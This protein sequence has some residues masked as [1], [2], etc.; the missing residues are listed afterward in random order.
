MLRAAAAAGLACLAVQ[1]L[2]QGKAVK[3]DYWPGMENAVPHVSG[4][5]KLTNTYDD[6]KD[7]ASIQRAK[8]AGK[9]SR[10]VNFKDFRWL[11]KSLDAELVAQEGR[12]NFHEKNSDGKSCAG[13]HGEEG[14]K[15]KGVLAGFPK[16]SK[17]AGRVVVLETQ[18]A[19]CAQ[20]HMKRT[21]WHEDTRANNMISMWLAILSDGQEINVN[22]KDPHIK[23]S[24]ERGK[25][26]F[27]RRTGHFHFACAAC[28]TP[29]TTSLYLRGQ[30]T[31]GYYGDA[32]EYPIYHFPNDTMNEDRGYIFTLQHQIRSCQK[33]SRMYYGAK[34]GSP[35]LTDIETFLRASS[36][37]YKI[38]APVKEYNID[39]D[40]LLEQ[41]RTAAK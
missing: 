34:E 7:A 41:Q 37:G 31:S 27:F 33:L 6:W 21:D 20:K 8:A 39:A 2:A 5:R 23:A 28:H 14:A 15:L 36:N 30:R 1:A 35:S 9:M 19:L 4:D 11:E 26:L 22:M 16:Y 3:H 10:D 24:Y 13:C 17:S 32:S 25:E 12:D 18:I 29:P 40:Y 38:S